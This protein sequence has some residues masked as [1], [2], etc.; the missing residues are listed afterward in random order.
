[1]IQVAQ[2][3]GSAEDHRERIEKMRDRGPQ[4]LTPEMARLGAEDP[5]LLLS[6]PWED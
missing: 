3:Q 4:K 6:S 1:V 2:I 5:S